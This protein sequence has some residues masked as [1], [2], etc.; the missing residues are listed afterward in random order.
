MSLRNEKV[1]VQIAKACIPLA[2]CFGVL[3]L[4]LIQ[5]FPKCMVWT[6]LFG[7]GL[8]LLTL[9]VLVFSDWSSIWNQYRALK[10]IL[11]IVLLFLGLTMIVVIWVYRGQ[12]ALSDIFLRYAGVMLRYYSP[13]L[14]VYI[15][16][17]TTILIVFM[18][19]CYFQHES[20]TNFYPP[21]LEPS[22]N[23]Y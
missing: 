8:S 20:F 19:I 15:P 18:A 17:F 5:F 12:I 11:G 22:G 13:L 1:A 16:I 9:S 7:A 4:V 21:Q 10:I 23:Y 2:L 6:S 3:F 14:F